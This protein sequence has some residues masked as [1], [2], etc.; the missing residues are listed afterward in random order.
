MAKSVAAAMVVT[1]ADVLGLCR[2]AHASVSCGRGS[3]AFSLMR[4][5]QSPGVERRYLCRADLCAAAISRTHSHV[6][7]SSTGDVG[8][9]FRSDSTDSQKPVP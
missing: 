5:S 8:S 6:Q 4:C 9:C 1:A 3:G 2:S 7:A